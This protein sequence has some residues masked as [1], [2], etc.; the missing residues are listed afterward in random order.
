MTIQ[1]KQETETENIKTIIR[2]IENDNNP[3][4]TNRK[5]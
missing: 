1:K 2:G 3:R 5:R 4:E